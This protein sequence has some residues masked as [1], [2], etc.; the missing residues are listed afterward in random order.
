M[1][2]NICKRILKKKKADEIKQKVTQTI[3][4]PL[5]KA[6]SYYKSTK[7]ELK[8]KFQIKDTRDL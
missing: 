2:K 8:R 1:Q 5:K 6:Y 3:T 7:E 4:A